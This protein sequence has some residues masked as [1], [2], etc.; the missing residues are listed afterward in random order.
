MY[1]F[2]GDKWLKAMRHQITATVGVNYS[3]GTS[4]SK[5]GYYGDDGDFVKYN[6]YDGS[7]YAA[8]NSNP[9]NVYN[10]RLINDLE[11][12]VKSKKDTTDEY[13]KTKFIDNL[14]LTTTYDAIADS[15]RWGDIRL[16]GRFTKLFE[17]VNI[18][19]NATFDPYAYSISNGNPVKI[20]EAW[21]SQNTGL[22][23]VKN[24]G[25]AANFSIRSK[26]KEK[27][28]KP[29]NAD[30]QVIQDEYEKD[31]SK[32]QDLK[33]PW[34]LTVN[35]NID[36]NSSPKSSDTDELFFENRVNNNLGIRGSFTIFKI[37]RISVNTGYD[38]TTME[39]IPSTIGLYVDLHCWEFTATVR[40]N[41]Y[42]QSYSISLNVK[43]PLLKD[44]KIKQENT[45]GGGTGFF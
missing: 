25:L 29:K 30:E 34:D 14:A 16:N 38:F 18:N 26:K 8:P 15:L 3:P 11:A 35:Y 27:K 36:L 19:Y 40:P 23:R 17:V 6:P 28:V 22:A 41:G 39:W 4:T 13:R 33:I 10:F 43:S 42:R 44:L 5:Y 7:I 45:F 12:K 21:A 31:P 37:F 24:A 32:F 2:K 9:S 1:A 20:N